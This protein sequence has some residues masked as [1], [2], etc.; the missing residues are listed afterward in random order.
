MITPGWY[1]DALG[2]PRSDEYV[3]VSGCR[4]HYLSWGEPGR[5]GLVF[6]HGG[7]AHAHWW[8]HVA[9]R[10]AADYRVAALDLSGH[11]DSERRDS[12]GLDQWADEVMSVAADAGMVGRPLVVG[13][14]MG[15]F[16]TMVTAARYSDDL[17]GVIVCDSPVTAPD[18][19]IDAARMGKAFGEPR[20]YPTRVEALERFRTIPAQD[21]YLDFVMEEIADRSLGEVEG[22]WR[23]KYDHHVF[24]G[25]HS[26]PRAVAREYLAAIRCRFALLRAEHGLVTEG[27]GQFMY[28]LLGRVNP[29]IEIPEAGHHMMLDQPLSLL[30]ALRTLAADWDH[31][32]PHTRD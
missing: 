28:E 5:R 11:G 30:T 4:I 3:V 9:A 17:A 22:G 12:Y 21:N 19:E 14:S 1:T 23:W 10:F 32:L 7:A 24:E 16:V 25:Q 20:I 18:P 8:T 31:S 29:V 6:V 15:G 27:I 26:N 2:V 13:H